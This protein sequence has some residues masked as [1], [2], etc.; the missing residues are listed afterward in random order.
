MKLS[1][2]RRLLIVFLIGFSLCSSALAQSYVIKGNV[3]DNE[4]GEALSAATIIGQLQSDTSQVAFA[5]S[6]QDGSFALRVS[7]YGRYCLKINFLGYAAKLTYVNVDQNDFEKKNVNIRLNKMV[8][9]L[10]EVNVV[11]TQNRI[12]VKKDTISYS[13]DAYKVNPDATV[14]E[15]I[16]KMPGLTVESQQVTA[17]G[18]QV[19]K[20]M[21]DGEEFFTSDPGAALSM[22]PADVVDKVEVID[23]KSDQAEFTGFD[24]GNT[25]KV[26]NIK[27]K[28]GKLSGQFGNVYAG[29]NFEDLYSIGSK[30][31]LFSGPKRFSVMASSNNLNKQ[32]FFNLDRMGM[33]GDGGNKNGINT[34]HSLGINY[35]RKW[36]DK[37]NVSGDYFF[38][39]IDN[40]NDTYTERQYLLS[41]TIMDGY[42]KKISVK[43]QNQNLGVNTRVEYK[44]NSSNSFLMR[45]SASFQKY[46]SNSGET[47]NSYTQSEQLV[48][49]LSGNDSRDNLGYSLSNSLLFRH[50]FNRNRRS[51]SVDVSESINH[52]DADQSTFSRTIYYQTD[53]TDLT[54][55]KKDNLNYSYRVNANVSYT[56][57][58]GRNGLLM[59]S[60]ESSINYN[61]SNIKTNAYDSLTSNYSSVDSASSSK[62]DYHT[63][64][65]SGGL[66]YRLKVSD[67]ANFAV[68]ANYKHVDLQGKQSF[69]VLVSAEHIY[70]EVEPRVEFKYSNNSKFNFQ[71][72]YNGQSRIPDV[73]NLYATVDNADPLNVSQ[74]NPNLNPQYTHSV[75]SRIRLANNNKTTFTVFDVEGKFSENYMGYYSI[76][77]RN[78]TVVDGNISLGAGASY[79]KPINCSGYQ[80][81]EV[82]VMQSFPITLIKS[83]A[84]VDLNS[85]Y[86]RTPGYVN[87]QK[88]YLNKNTLNS[89]L[90]LTSN[91]SKKVDFTLSYRANYSIINSSVQSH[92]DGN[93]Y[94]GNLSGRIYVIPYRRIVLISDIAYSHYIGLDLAGKNRVQWN[95]SVAYKFMKHN[96]GE[97]MLSVYDILNSNTDVSRNSTT[98]YID[99]TR[100]S[101]LKQYFL[102]TFNYKINNFDI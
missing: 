73:N 17:Y 90:R 61:N 15:L 75:G 80:S 33:A 87:D 36:N 78:D 19:T 72:T 2:F 4:T 91:I 86:S 96:R 85:N 99:D 74:G 65:Q 56:E 20:I 88:Y 31:N 58:L 66:G 101:I 12:T 21:V 14:G 37:W 53:S 97:L 3:F 69:P 41:D 24:D 40:H 45:S 81:I 57:P 44:L 62:N 10:K 84:S 25:S 59:L 16:A 94:T 38:N 76:T 18:E 92:I 22:L 64:S 42:T 29:T 54:D 83:N 98:Y 30:L 28:S 77:A 79:S 43:G 102:L 9:V 95:A 68:N 63:Y 100:S 60:Y 1:F 89:S 26:I 7:N 5:T 46:S 47:S 34:T 32:E 23:K 82:R 52:T 49:S 48:N 67:N 51:I 70:N 39:Y 71:F 35:N 55:Q 27:T 50:K 93:Y 11:K 8:F 13:A 6:M